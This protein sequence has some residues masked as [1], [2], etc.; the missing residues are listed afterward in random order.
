MAALLGR[1]GVVVYRN[2]S[3]ELRR[4][5]TGLLAARAEEPRWS[6][7]VLDNS[8][9]R[10]AEPAFA[11]W[12]DAYGWSGANLGFG[13]AHNQLMREAFAEG[14]DLYVCV[15]PDAV[16]HPRCLAELFA[17]VDRA[18]RPG[19]VEAR[20]LPEEHP[21]PYD[22]RTHETPWC[23][24]TVLLVT[25]AAFEATGGFDERFFMYCEDVDLSW[26]VRG[27]GL[28]TRVAPAALAHHYVEERPLARER[29]IAVRR[30][31][32]LL[33][34]KFG[35]AGFARRRLDELAA[36]G[37]QPPA[38]SGVALAPRAARRHASF[39]HRLRFAPSRW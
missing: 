34:T 10:G 1:I 37:G 23:A 2:S 13:R 18:V 16:L 38:L 30:S 9:D 22:P 21:K 36:L 11:D 20:I 6:L 15:N 17:E 4:L 25:R 14:R 19:L 7:R 8:P 32:A 12:P 3:D 31:A 35:H 5:L 28:E 33:A 39:S 27:A 26:R 29:E 24:G